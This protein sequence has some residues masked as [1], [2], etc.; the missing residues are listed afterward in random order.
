MY[1]VFDYALNGE[2]STFL[3]IN[4]TLNKIEAQFYIAQ[5]VSVLSFLKSKNVV[6]RDL[7]PCNILL[8]ENWHLL[9]GDFGTAKLQS[10]KSSNISTSSQMSS[11][12]GTAL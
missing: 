11:C 12:S 10:A 8:N 9:L 5:L 3:K 2:L 1:L 7:K 4:S 6:H